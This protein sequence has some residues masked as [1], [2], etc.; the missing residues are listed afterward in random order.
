[1]RTPMQWD[2][3]PNA[4]FS[5]APPD[6]L[7]APVIDDPIYGYQTV[8]VA[9]QEE[10]PNSL[11]NRMRTLISLRKRHPAFA[12][13]D[14]EFLECDNPAVLAFVRSYRDQVIVVV[15]NVS[16]ETQPVDLDLSKFAGRSACD[17]LQGEDYP[18]IGRERYRLDLPPYQSRWLKLE[19]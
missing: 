4:G 17:I 5:D 8:N 11:L 2:A 7:Y 3:S 12:R 10:D 13:G 19:G 18:V 9:A 14:F 6:K 16:G 15:H 1:V